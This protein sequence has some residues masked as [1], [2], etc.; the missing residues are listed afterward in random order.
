MSLIALW[1]NNSNVN[2]VVVVVLILINFS[3][4][5]EKKLKKKKRKKKKEKKKKKVKTSPVSSE[6]WVDPW[7]RSNNTRPSK[8]K[9]GHSSEEESVKKIKKRSKYK[10]GLELPILVGS[11]P[12]QWERS[13]RI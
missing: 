11:R 2:S 9:R 5:T 3:S 6:E 8:G 1:T 12:Y 13:I 10:V 4:E 7:V